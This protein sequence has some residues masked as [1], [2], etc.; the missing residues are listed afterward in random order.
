MLLAGA[1]KELKKDFFLKPPEQF[2]YLGQSGCFEV[3][4]RSDVHEFEEMVTAMK[5]LNID[6]KAQYLIFQ[7][8]AG[9]LHL[10][11]LA[12][13]PS[14]DVENGSKVSVVAECKRVAQLFGIN[15]DGLEKALC[16]RDT[17]INGES[18]MIPLPVEKAVDQR[19]ALAKY[20]YGKVFD[21]IVNRV[22]SSLFRGKIANNIGVL[23]IFGFEVFKVN[24]FEQLCIN[25]CNERLQTFFNEIIFEG[26][27]KI[28][29]AEGLPIDDIA[30]TVSTLLI[31]SLRCHNVIVY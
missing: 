29:Q 18:M 21:Y 10:G 30:F 13:M 12:F 25:Y 16:F 15:P 22:N 14:R 23:D 26:E 2:W 20:V 24:S 8:V 17:I 9:I 1:Q 27:I 11:N 31:S 7:C 19:D 4:R 5:N 3:N 6:E 28:Y